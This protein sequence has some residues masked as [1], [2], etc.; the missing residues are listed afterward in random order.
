MDIALALTVLQTIISDA[1]EAI[2]LFNAVKAVLTQ[3]GDPTTAQ[4]TALIEAQS[5]AHLALQKPTP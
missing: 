5:A 3:S 4:W 1:P 2:A